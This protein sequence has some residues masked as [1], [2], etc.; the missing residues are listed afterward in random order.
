LQV[1]NP[2]SLEAHRADLV[3]DGEIS[4]EANRRVADFLRRLWRVRNVGVRWAAG[5]LM[6]GV[7]LAF[8]LPVRYEST[9]RLM[10]PDSNNSAALM[11][12][13]S[14]GGG[15]SGIAQDMLGLKSSGALYVAMVSSDSV[16]DA[17]INRFDLRK[18]YWCQT[19]SAA[20]KKLASRTSVAE[21][22][23]SGIVTITVTD[24]DAKRAAALANAYVE[25]LNRTLANVSTSA[26]R[27]ERL[28]LEQRLSEVGSD[29]TE[30]EQQL[31]VY[32]SKHEVF[33]AKDQGRAL[34]GLGAELSGARGAAEAELSALEQVYGDDNVRVKQARARI[35]E[36][37]RQIQDVRGKGVQ[38]P[39]GALTPS[40]ARLP[41]L[42]MGYS[43]LYRRAK[44][45]ETVYEVLTKQYELAK[46][47]EAKDIPT[48][49]PLDLPQVPEI[50]SFPPRKVIVLLCTLF[51][52]AFGLLVA[53]ARSER[54]I[55]ESPMMELC[56][57]I[58]A[59][60]KSL[61]HPL[62]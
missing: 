31:A 42:A 57:E 26:A 35:S 53:V 15:A 9:A 54:R 56:G 50:K 29:L 34:M 40:L 5:G 47:Q 19:Y 30:S 16:S 14:L 12:A 7:A 62:P 37:D 45:D 24:S 60:L 13:A 41:N 48:V 6:A 39:T 23:K 3:S 18:V 44:I 36:L 20:R 58:I 38:D 43:D 28:F 52:F 46:V 10:P 27:R 59:D 51:A 2:T 11:V 22:R 49:K 17:L 33:D 25:E 8:L 4:Q 21:D 55:A 61:R 32:S 1:Q